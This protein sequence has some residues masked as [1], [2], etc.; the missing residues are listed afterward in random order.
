MYRHL[1]ILLVVLMVST[2]AEEPYRP[3]FHFS[4]AKNWMND[5]NGPFY[6]HGEYHL[7]YQHNPFGTR[8]GHMSWGHAVS[9]DLLHWKHLPVALPERA[10]HMIFSGCVVVDEEN[11]SGLGPLVAVYTGYKPESGHQAQYLARSQDGYHWEFVSEEPVL[12]I[13][14]TDFRDPRVFR[15]ENQFVMVIAMPAERKVRFYR[16]PDLKQWTYLSEFGPAGA[17]GGA[18]ECP[19]LFELPVEG[20]EGET[21]WVLQVDLDRRAVCGGS[22]SQYFVGRFDGTTFSLDQAEPDSDPPSGNRVGSSF[23]A[24]ASFLNFEIRGGRDPEHLRVELVEGQKVVASITGFNSE[25]WDWYTFDLTSHLGKELSLRV[26]DT[27][28][29]KLWGWLEVGQVWLSPRPVVTSRYRARW[30]D[31]GP[32]FYAATSWSNLEG[33]RVLIAWMNNWLY[34]QDTPTR[35]WRSSMTLPR[36]LSLRLQEGAIELHQEPPTEILA[37]RK[38]VSFSDLPPGRGMVEWQVSEAP[39]QF[40]VLGATLRVEDGLLVLDRSNSD[41]LVTDFHQAYIPQARMRLK[42][43]TLRVIYDQ[44]CLEVFTDRGQTMTALVF[45]QGKPQRPQFQG[46][47]IRCWSID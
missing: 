27:K 12:D 20:L 31:H 16:S 28:T 40:Q 39:Q 18:W 34:G 17:I 38:A 2:G 29:E 47:E 24:E 30:L 15:F 11:R 41:A 32:D 43:D 5:P 26:V 33:R 10:D 21:R 45:P 3:R 37:L 22:G 13:G 35:G 42:G 44:S 6:R 46:G 25:I 4:P 8:W 36:E 7:F 19:D 1:A 14:S 9:R 23:R